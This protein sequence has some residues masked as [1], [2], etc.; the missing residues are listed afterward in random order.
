[1]IAAVCFVALFLEYSARA[2]M[3]VVIVAMVKVQQNEE[4][5]H[6]FNSSTVSLEDQDVCP[7]KVNTESNSQVCLIHNLRKSHSCNIIKFH[8]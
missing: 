4:E 5:S 3:S 8:F 1:M 7:G 6:T 2:C